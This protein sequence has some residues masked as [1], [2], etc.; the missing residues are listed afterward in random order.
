MKCP[1]CGSEMIDKHLVGNKL[2]FLATPPFCPRCGHDEKVG[3]MTVG[4]DYF[5]PF[6]GAKKIGG[7]KR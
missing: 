5:Q 6:Q 7:E 1:K 4:A 3:E 2:Q